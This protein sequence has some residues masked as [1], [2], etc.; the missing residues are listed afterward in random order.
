ML[1]ATLCNIILLAFAPQ[2]GRQGYAQETAKTT[3][4]EGATD[5]P[6][7]VLRVE[8]FPLNLVDPASPV[9]LV[10]LDIFPQNPYNRTIKKA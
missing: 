7:P 4:T 3:E 1:P 5:P 2:K 10:T 8:T 6:E 9:S